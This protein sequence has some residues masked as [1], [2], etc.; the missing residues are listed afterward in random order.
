[1]VSGGVGLFHGDSFGVCMEGL[2]VFLVG[3]CENVGLFIIEVEGVGELVGGGILLGEF[4]AISGT[5]ESETD[6]AVLGFAARVRH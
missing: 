4:F 2:F 1:M 3:V 5:F 6:D